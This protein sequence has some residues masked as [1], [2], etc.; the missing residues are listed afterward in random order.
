MKKKNLKA[1]QDELAKEYACYVLITCDSATKDGKMQVEMSYEGDPTLA[2]YLLQGAQD[3]L[4]NE[5]QQNE[6]KLG[7]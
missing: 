7:V 1:I 3:F 4:E 6:A 5:E 2:A